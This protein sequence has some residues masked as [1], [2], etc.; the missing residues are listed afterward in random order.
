MRRRCWTRFWWRS[1]ADRP[2]AAHDVDVVR[3]NYGVTARRPGHDLCVARRRR[4]HRRPMQGRVP[5]RFKGGNPAGR[6]THVYDENHARDCHLALLGTPSRVAQLRWLRV[7]LPVPVHVASS[8]PGRVA[9]EL[10]SRSHGALLK[11]RRHCDCRARPALVERSAARAPVACSR[12][13]RP[14]RSPRACRRGSRAAPP[15]AFQGLVPVFDLRAWKAVLATVT[16]QLE[17]Q[18]R[19]GHARFDS[20][21]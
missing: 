4:T 6:Q 17:Q 15:I 16:F 7:G 20:I 19:T 1:R 13:W 10:G 9:A 5:G 12:P 3:Q 21:C 11:G 18:V 2:R 8:S 14:D